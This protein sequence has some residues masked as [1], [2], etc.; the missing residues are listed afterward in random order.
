MIFCRNFSKGL[1]LEGIKFLENSIRLSSKYE[2]FINPEDL[3]MRL[4]LARI[5]F[6]C[7]RSQCLRLGWCLQKLLSSLSFIET[8]TS[9]THP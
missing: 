1:I 4:D 6:L 8:K 9:L 5:G 3:A 7:R 2:G